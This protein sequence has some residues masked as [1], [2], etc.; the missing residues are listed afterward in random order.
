MPAVTVRSS[1]NGLPI[2]TTESPTSILSES[3]SAS[4]VRAR[5][6]ASTFSRAM[7]VEGS[8]P[9][10]VAFRV[11]SFEKRTSIARGTFDDVVVGDDVPFLVEHEAGAERLLG[12]LLELLPELVGLGAAARRRRD[13]DDARAA[14]PVDLVDRQA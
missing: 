7:S 5:A 10:S 3:A 14:A 2:A 8:L 11:S 1:P 9:T 4:G 12:G 6:L 13:L